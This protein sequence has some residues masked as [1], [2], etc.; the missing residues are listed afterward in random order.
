MAKGRGKAK[1]ALDSSFRQKSTKSTRT[2]KKRS[3]TKT[4]T[5]KTTS[6]NKIGTAWKPSDVLVVKKKK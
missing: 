4:K 6:G 1:R 3:P 2:H 5:K